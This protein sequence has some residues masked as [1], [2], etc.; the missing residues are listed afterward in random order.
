MNMYNSRPVLSLRRVR[1]SGLRPLPGLGFA[2]IRFWVIGWAV[3]PMY[4]VIPQIR[5]VVGWVG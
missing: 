4:T 1:L 2:I 3:I 5:V